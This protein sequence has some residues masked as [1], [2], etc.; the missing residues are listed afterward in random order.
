MY[1]LPYLSML[2]NGKKSDVAGYSVNRF[3]IPYIDYLIFL[4]R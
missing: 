2:F 1:I 4:G 3:R